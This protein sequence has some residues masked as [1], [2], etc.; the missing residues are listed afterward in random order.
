MVE[1]NKK[2]L[3]L[4]TMFL[5]IRMLL[6]LVIS[7][8]TT[9]VI[10]NALGASDYG[11]Y[12][13]VGGFVAMLTFLNGAMSNASQRFITYELGRGVQKKIQN[14]FAQVRILHIGI[15]VIILLL[16]ET[17]G[18][19]F[20]NT[21]LNIPE[22][23]E[24]A[25][26]CVYQLSVVSTIF[27]ILSV[28]YNS[29]IIAH[30]NMKIYAYVG[31]YEGVMKLFVCYVLY[32]TSFDRLIMYAFLLSSVSCSVI[33]FY[34]LYCIRT[35][36]ET[37]AKLSLDIK[38]LGEVGTFGGWALFGSIST[39][40]M[41]QGVNI[42]VNMFFNTVVNAARGI[43]YQIDAALR[44]FIN[45]FQ[46]AVNPQIV[47]AYSVK[48]LP[49]M[50]SLLFFSSKMS[51]FIVFIL[52]LPLIINIDYILNLWL[53]VV[54]EYT[55]EF[56]RLVLINSL[57]ITFSGALSISAQA[58][59]NI[60]HYQLF[61][62]IFLLL[63]LPISYVLYMSGYPPQSAVLVSICIEIFLMFMRLQFLTFMI[64]LK[65]RKFVTSVLVPSMACIT[66]TLPLCYMIYTYIPVKT[67]V[68]FTITSCLYVLT[69][70][71]II[72]IVG[73]NESQRTT[74]FREMKKVIS[75]IL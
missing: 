73:L 65:I 8:F 40:S 1:G 52:A 55:A 24:F 54:P 20:V 70:M 34:R 36:S 49:L 19:W 42:L 35:Y 71:S 63:N 46:T 23:R 38:K 17:I 18:L 64:A 5:Y 6:L 33:L 31:I 27:T 61:M 62:G 26:N 21:K 69:S 7:L 50:H 43:S 2:R 45:N 75:K 29:L 15:S 66:V 53:D 39:L 68:S 67:F 11:T 74:I 28:P 58:T 56:T 25:A 59:G 22:G 48:D 72:L 41:T 12:N 60:R 9:K 3:A 37:K 51:F 14:V 57:I 44:M 13:V 32:V 16:A 4:N 10:L 30:E 47:K